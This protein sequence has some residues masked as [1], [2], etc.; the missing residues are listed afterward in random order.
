VVECAACDAVHLG[1]LDA[2]TPERTTT[3]VTA[4]KRE[5]VLA[6]D[7]HC[8]TVPGCRR[9]VGLDL[10]HIKYQSQSGGHEL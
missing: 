6:R 10:H 2:A 8:C 3:T 9:T 5:H 7:G 4:R 1:S